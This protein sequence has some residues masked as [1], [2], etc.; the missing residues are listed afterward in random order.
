METYGA[1]I[2]SYW[3]Y[4]EIETVV[5]R[6]RTKER[7]RGERALL[8]PSPLILLKKGIINQVNDKSYQHQK[9]IGKSK[10]CRQSISAAPLIFFSLLFPIKKKTEI[11]S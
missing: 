1:T 10:N 8:C 11:R 4:Y 3:G 5:V 9:F 6:H 7:G 2:R